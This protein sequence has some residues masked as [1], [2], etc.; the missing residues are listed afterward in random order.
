MQLWIIH[1]FLKFW[2]VP[3]K[4]YELKQVSL[5]YICIFYVLIS[6]RIAGDYKVIFFQKNI[7]IARGGGRFLESCLA[8]SAGRIPRR[9]F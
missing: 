6:K 2:N 3:N 9:D 4:R 5:L 8:G 7:C 1:E